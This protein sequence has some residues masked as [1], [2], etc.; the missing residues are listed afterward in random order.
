M[1]AACPLSRDAVDARAGR[2][3]AALSLLVVI[4]A[5]WGPWP[6]VHLALAGDFALRAAGWRRLSPIARASRLIRQAARLEPR[7]VN[8]GPK[9][10]AALLGTGFAL[11]TAL[12][13]L[14]GQRGAALSV[15]G[16]LGLCA[17]LEAAFG[18]CLACHLW[19]LLPAP[20]RPRF[21]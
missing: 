9:R 15:A 6:W 19:P 4:L 10:F 1:T 14:A 7:P 17:G 21:Q 2:M 18:F 20:L 16:V 13:F 8:A 11:A 12:L 5:S 3:A